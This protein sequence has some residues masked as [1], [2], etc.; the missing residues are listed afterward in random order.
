MRKFSHRSLYRLL[1]DF[2]WSEVTKRV[3]D[4]QVLT[5][6]FIIFQHHQS[7]DIEHALWPSDHDT[8]LDHDTMSPGSV[9]PSFPQSLA[10]LASLPIFFSFRHVPFRPITP[11]SNDDVTD[12]W[13]L[14]FCGPSGNRL[15]QE[16]KSWGV[17]HG[18]G[19]RG[20]DVTKS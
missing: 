8:R 20:N 12:A 6:C 9:T 10:R 1:Q 2:S 7:V 3:R 11:N 19:L 16:I 5:F 15:C 14:P 13:H 4:F 17:T 18:D